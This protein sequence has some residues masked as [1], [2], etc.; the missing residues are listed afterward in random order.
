MRTHEFEFKKTVK[1]TKK[2]KA[3]S[4]DLTVAEA[5]VLYGFCISGS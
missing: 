4:I 1:R 2:F 3:I 5:E